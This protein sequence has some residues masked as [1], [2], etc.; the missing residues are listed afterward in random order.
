M[1][2][3]DVKKAEELEEKY[4]TSLQTRVISP[5]L[6]KFTFVFSILFA[7][8]HY[9][10]AGT[11]VPIDYWHMGT[12]MAGVILLVFIG[13]PATRGI[14]NKEYRTSTWWRYGNVPV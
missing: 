9:I 14:Q 3:L 1:A 4:D 11:G 8:Y 5:L 7:A 13:F 2:E 6:V 10:T 12:H